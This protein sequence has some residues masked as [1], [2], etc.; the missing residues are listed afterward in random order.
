MFFRLKTLRKKSGSSAVD[1]GVLIYGEDQGLV[2]AERLAIGEPVAKL[3]KTLTPLLSTRSG[4]EVFLLI[5][6][7]RSYERNEYI[8][9]II[10][11]V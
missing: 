5:L 3:W 6:T 10:V 2:A 7:Y 1:A 4:F 9:E 11:I 8:H